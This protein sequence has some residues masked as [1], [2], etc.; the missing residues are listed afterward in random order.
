M[1]AVGAKDQAQ[2]MKALVAIKG[3]R[4]VLTGINFLLARWESRNAIV[5][6]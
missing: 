2:E 3:P 4:N 6:V 5:K 1:V